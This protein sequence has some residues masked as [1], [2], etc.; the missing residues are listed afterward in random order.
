V[1]KEILQI[2][3]NI[4]FLV[5]GIVSALP[6]VKFAW[7]LNHTGIFNFWRTEDLNLANH[8]PQFPTEITRFESI[9]EE[10]HLNWVLLYNKVDIG[11]LLKEL[12]PFDYLLL[13]NG[14]IE[15]LDY[16]HIQKS[17]RNIKQ[18]I[19]VNLINS[20]KIKEQISWIL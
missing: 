13:V 20:K 8:N 18:V 10:N 1:K 2:T 5:L 14:G 11:L 15:F 6:P 3:Q 9:D 16:T 4:D 17:I 12:K 19:S 7:Q